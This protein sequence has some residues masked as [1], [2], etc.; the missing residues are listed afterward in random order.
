MKPLKDVFFSTRKEDLV[1]L[2]VGG[3]VTQ[4]ILPKSLFYVIYYSKRINNIF[5]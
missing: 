3:D 2:T 1:K 5:P 4:M